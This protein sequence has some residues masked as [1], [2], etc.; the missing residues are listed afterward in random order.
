M[1]GIAGFIDRSGRITDAAAA[2]AAMSE[3]IRHRGPDGE[4]HSFDPERRIALVHRR[5]AIQD[6]S[7]DGAQPMISGGGRFEIVYNGEIYDFPERRTE[8]GNLGH[9]F[10]TG[11]D[12]EVLLAG[13]E[14]WGIESTLERIDGMFAFAVH[15]RER[16]EVVLA[17]DRAGQKPLL[18]AE[19][20]GAVAF[21]SDLRA[22]ESMPSPF[23]ARLQGIDEHSLEWFLRLGAVPWGR[24]IRPGVE[25]VPP[26]GIFRIGLSR[27]RIQRDRWWTPPIPE[28]LR[29][30]D[31]MESP[32][33]RETIDIL[34][35][36]VHRRCRADREVGVFLSGGIDSRLIAG[37]ASEV[38]PGLPCFTLAMPGP[39]DESKDARR[40][41]DRL[42]CPHHV[43]RPSDTEILETAIELP[44]IAD[45]PFADSS[46]LATTLLARAARQSIVVALGGDGGDELFGGYRRHAAFRRR[47][48][49]AGLQRRLAMMIDGL[50]HAITG[51]VPLGR[52][53]L[54][55]AAR[56]RRSIDPAGI[57]HLTLRETQG[58]AA[59]VLGPR[60]GDPN[61][62]E[63]ATAL[64][65]RVA[66]SAPWDGLETSLTDV[67]Q[68]MA[69]D[70]RT[71]LPD[72][73]L[74]KIDRGTMSVALE[75]RAPLL[76]REVI[77]HAFGLPTTA[78]FDRG[79]G[80]APLR[81]ALRSM[82]LPDG[83]SKRG[84]AVPAFDWLRGPLK[85]H[86]AS[87]LL[88]PVDDPLSPTAVADLFDAVQ[89]GR[90]D[91][92]TACWTLYCWR[93]WLR[94]RGV[95]QV[96]SVG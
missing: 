20:D 16:G 83:G 60:P 54:A 29:D 61:A 65:A 53:S 25:Q 46:L 30:G 68:L 91:L 7:S 26:G 11:T 15:D 94:N 9:R 31:S 8:L 42:D 33:D 67:R 43:I 93:G 96:G 35:E 38:R 89:R 57:D 52:G 79:G 49:A 2:M 41:A 5:L 80:R 50:P 64:H 39:F 62:F 47:G 77:K 14:T 66:A 13:F 23:D 55:E 48:I 86:A 73:P 87:L 10:R 28:P 71:Y 44:A 76:G 69:A 22:L 82:N 6:P 63:R 70:F 81:A 18:L 37:L 36:S 45:E 84:F 51:R 12:T 72:D 19:A 95:V 40:I 58:D 34:R 17:R 59:A 78:L 75:H 4:G 32:T 90:R 88:D 27:G 1:C 21:A 85:D 56:R 92:A 74:V 24:S 3:A